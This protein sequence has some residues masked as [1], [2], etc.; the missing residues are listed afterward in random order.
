VWSPFYLAGVHHVLY[1]KEVINLSNVARNPPQKT[2]PAIENL[3]FAT[4][5]PKHTYKEQVTNLSIAARNPPQKT[6]PAIENLLI[7]HNHS[8][9]HLISNIS[10]ELISRIFDPTSRS[11]VFTTQKASELCV[12]L[13][14]EK[15]GWSLSPP[16]L[17]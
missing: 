3:L 11:R 16:T 7:R 8:K 14:T 13:T 15:Y 10:L 2:Q 5:S 1:K 6:Q 17:F 4:I 9:T 12:M